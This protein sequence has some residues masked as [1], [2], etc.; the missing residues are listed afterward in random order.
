MIERSKLRDVIKA[1]PILAILRNVADEQLISYVQ[2]VMNGG[3]RFFE[4]A[5]NSKNAFEQI[6]LLKAAYG[7]ELYVGAGTVL[8]KEL[9][10]TAIKS[11][12][13]FLLSPSSDTEV[14]AYCSK[15]DIPLI[16][17]ALTPSDVSKCIAYGFSDIKLF[18]AGEMPA[19]YIKSLKGPF[20][21]TEYIAIGGVNG[22]NIQ[23]FFQS[24]YI[25]AG[26]GSNLM[27]PDICRNECWADGTEYVKNLIKRAGG[28]RK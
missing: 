15:M 11:G 7:N 12:A 5:L 28:D 6:R 20:E 26:L 2:A 10:E 24:G 1:N 21:E 25:G 14:L 13:D 3:V 9:A 22:N 17:G 27:P 16:P 4:V 19:S 18:P 23:E 8:T